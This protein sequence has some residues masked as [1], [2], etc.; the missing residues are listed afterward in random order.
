[1][2]IQTPR[3]PI[4]VSFFYSLKQVVIIGGKHNSLCLRREQRHLLF[5]LLNDTTEILAVRRTYISKH[6]Y[7]RLYHLMQSLHLAGTRYSRLEQRQLMPLAHLPH[8]ERDA[9]L[10]VV[11]LWAS[12]H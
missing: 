8:R 11:T 7:C 12:Y 10:R 9:Y 6:S 5:N 4:N 1:M 3:E 2:A